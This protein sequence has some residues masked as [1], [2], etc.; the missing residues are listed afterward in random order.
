MVRSLA[1]LHS[2]NICHRDIKPH[3]FVIK[4]NRIFLCDF[5]AAKVIK[6]LNDDIAYNVRVSQDFHGDFR[7][8]KFKTFNLS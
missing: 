4:N 2:L 5:G 3:N 6:K 8:S 7:K 1:Y